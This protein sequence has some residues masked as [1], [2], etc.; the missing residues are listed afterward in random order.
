VNEHTCTHCK[1]H[2]NSGGS[3]IGG[4]VIGA[5]VGV[6]V[7]MMLAP[8]T[9]K[10]TRLKIKKTAKKVKEEAQPILNE[11]QPVIEKLAA[12]SAPLRSE[13]NEKITH[14]IEEPIDDDI[15]KLLSKNKFFKG[16]F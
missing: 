3:F 10:N 15:K 14:L 11:I 6:T 8:D 2:N 16:T 13:I 12:A 7:G 5:I 1:K 4:A 9:G